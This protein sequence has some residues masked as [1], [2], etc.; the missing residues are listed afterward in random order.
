VK[1]SPITTGMPW[2][3]SRDPRNQEGGGLGWIGKV[4]VSCTSCGQDAT[5]EL[6]VHIGVCS[7]RDNTVV[8]NGVTMDQ[9]Y[10][11][12]HHDASM[13][14]RSY[15]ESSNSIHYAAAEIAA[16]LQLHHLHT[17]CEGCL[18]QC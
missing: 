4:H 18:W 11:V 17:M 16:T 12:H 5:A 9:G 3:S 1:R 2:A 7:H 10:L 6:H 15:I 13:L 14:A 8:N